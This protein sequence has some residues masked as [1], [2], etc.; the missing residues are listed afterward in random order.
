MMAVSTKESVKCAYHKQYMAFFRNIEVPGNMNVCD[1]DE[2]T[3]GLPTG[4]ASTVIDIPTM[5]S[6]NEVNGTECFSL[7]TYLCQE[8][9]FN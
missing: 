4:E 9:L 5:I 6:M 2:A 7:Y 1:V 8:T 3:P